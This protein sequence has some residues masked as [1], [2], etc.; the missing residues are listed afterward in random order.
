MPVQGH[1]RR[2]LTWK[3]LRYGLWR[4]LEQPKLRYE[5]LILVGNGPTCPGMAAAI[6]T[7]GRKYDLVHAGSLHYAHTAYGYAAARAAHRPFVLTPH[8]HVE[9]RETWDIGYLRGILDHAD[10]IFANTEYERQFHISRG[11]DPNWVVTAGVGLQPAEYSFEGQGVSRRRLDIPADAQVVLFL[12]RQ[13]DYKGARQSPG[14]G[15]DVGPDPPP[16][17]GVGGW[18]GERMEPGC[19]GA[20][21]RRTVGA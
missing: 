13:V 11:R 20:L 17:D 6:A 12:G 10:L 1:S 18:T 5:P 21:C 2:E 4:Y 16:A 9:Q 14:R 15:P 7:K 19:A 3:L 8:V